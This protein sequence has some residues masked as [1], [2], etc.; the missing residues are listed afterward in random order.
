MQNNQEVV[1]KF[2]KALKLLREKENLTQEELAEKSEISYKNIQYLEARNP[3]CPSLVTLHKL[4]KAFNISL[5][6][7]FKKLGL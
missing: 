6:G 3:T 2:S 1:R 5:T 4:A 7:L